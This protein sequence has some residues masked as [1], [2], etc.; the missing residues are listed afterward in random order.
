MLRCGDGSLYCGITTDLVRRVD[1]HRSGKG[2]RYTK[3]RGPLVVAAS[4]EIGG[5]GDA[6]RAELAYKGLS[7]VAKEALLAAKVVRVWPRP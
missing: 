4:W 1:Q 2:A 6:L 5:Q 3:G 7:R